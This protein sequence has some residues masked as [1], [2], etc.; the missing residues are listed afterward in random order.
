[1]SITALL[2]NVRTE[3]TA[4]KSRAYAQDIADANNALADDGDAYSVE[5]KGKYFAVAFSVDGEFIAYL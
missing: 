5:E 2:N 4:M 1:M 3:F